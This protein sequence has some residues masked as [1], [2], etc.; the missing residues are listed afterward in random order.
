MS[1]E[2]PRKFEVVPRVM[3]CAVDTAGIVFF[4]SSDNPYAN[5]RN[6][7]EQMK[8]QPPWFILERF[9]GLAHKEITPKFPKFGRAHIVKPEQV[10]ALGTNYMICDPC[11]AGRNFCFAWVRYTDDGICYFYREW[12]SQVAEIPGY[13]FVGPWAEPGSGRAGERDGKMA[14]GQRGLGFTLVDYKK[15]IARL[16]NWPEWH[17]WMNGEYAGDKRSERDIVASWNERGRGGEGGGGKEAGFRVQGSGG[18]AQGSGFREKRE[19]IFERYMDSRFGNSERVGEEGNTTL[20]EDFAE[21]GMTFLPTGAS[22]RRSID[23]GITLINS[24]LGYDVEK[25]VDWTNRPR[26]Y[27]SSDC[28]NLIWAMQNWTGADGQKGACKDMIDLVRYPVLKG[29]CWVGEERWEARGGG[30]Y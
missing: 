16:E 13:G 28:K 8:H 27:F 11:G 10:P 29:C 14:S 21:L 20:I 24:A 2:A 15:E 30:Y 6:I 17:A 23:E 22:E 26:M 3:R 7:Y 25:P 4:H 5:A 12:P 19:E 9:Y 18:G 1:E